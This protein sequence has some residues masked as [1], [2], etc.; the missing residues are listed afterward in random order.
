[1]KHLIISTYYFFNLA[2]AILKI[3][4]VEAFGSL[5]QVQIGNDT[6]STA[7]ISN[8]DGVTK[9]KP[10]YFFLERYMQAY[11]REITEFFDCIENDK[12][13]PAGIEDGLQSVLIGR[14]ATKS[15]KEGRPI[16]LKDM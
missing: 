10:L 3:S 12:V 13:V 6:V 4:S 16:K 15:Y 11:A 14:A 9:E 2:K 1:M 7:V 5:G 8:A